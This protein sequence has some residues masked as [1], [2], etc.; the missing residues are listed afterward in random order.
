MKKVILALVAVLGMSTAYAADHDC[1]K[2][3]RP[4]DCNKTAPKVVFTGKQKLEKP[5]RV[6]VCHP[7]WAR[8]NVGTLDGRKTRWWGPTISH[9]KWSANLPAVAE[10]CK[11]FWVKPGSLISTKASCVKKVISTKKMIAPDKYVME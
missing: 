1:N 7:Y 11:V 9:G 5:I 2:V 3:K 8:M 10:E 6:V 4:E